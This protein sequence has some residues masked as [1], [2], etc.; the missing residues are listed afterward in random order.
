MWKLHWILHR[1]HHIVAFFL[2]CKVGTLWSIPLTISY[3]AWPQQSN[4]HVFMQWSWLQ[5]HDMQKGWLGDP[6]AL[7][8]TCCSLSIA[9]ECACGQHVGIPWL[10]LYAQIVDL[11]LHCH[12]LSH[13]GC[14]SCESTV[15]WFIMKTILWC[16]GVASPWLRFHVAIEFHIYHF[17]S[18][19]DHGWAC[20]WFHE[21]HT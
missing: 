7:A 18:A 14:R 4:V 1:W 5:F 3:C 13:S 17:A 2:N 10:A 12:L 11:L 8:P 15:Q 19:F 20:C 16:Y 6:V 21:N 9:I